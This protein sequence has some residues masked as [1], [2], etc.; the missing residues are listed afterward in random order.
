MKHL[1]EILGHILAAQALV[2]KDGFDNILQPGLVK[3]MLLAHL[4]GHVVHKTKHG[5]D[6]FDPKDPSRGFEYLCLQET[7]AT[8]FVGPRSFQLSR[9]FRDPPRR[10]ESVKRITRNAG[11]YFAV[12]EKTDPLHVK[13]IY[14][15]PVPAVLA[16]VERM[17][18]KS[19]SD[20]SHIHLGYSWM[21]KHGVLVYGKPIQLRSEA[22]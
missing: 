19:K 8:G 17:L 15:V 20:I 7:G 4:L 2:Q 10:E 11:F 1:Q 22:V 12:F 3:E 5:V 21:V 18:D 14:D 16:E 13:S 6:A 9:M